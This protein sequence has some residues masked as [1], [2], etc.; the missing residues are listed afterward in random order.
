MPFPLPLSPVA[1]EYVSMVFD[2]GIIKAEYTVAHID[3]QIAEICIQFRLDNT[4]EEPLPILIDLR[5]LR[6][7]SKQAR[8][9]LASPRAYE[10]VAACALITNNM[11]TRLIARFF[12]HFSR[13]PAPTRLFG[14]KEKAEEWLRSLG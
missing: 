6:T 9:L 1:N 8:D 11:V 10:K 12:V 3:H 4:P 2:R 13:P 7:I 5:N 14:N